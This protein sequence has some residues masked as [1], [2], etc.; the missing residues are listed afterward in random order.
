MVDRFIAVS[1]Y[2]ARF[3]CG[4]LRIPSEK[5][6]VVPLGIDMSGYGRRAQSDEGVFRIG[7][8][9]RIAPEKGLRELVQAY[10]KLRQRTEGRHIRLEA[11]GYTSP[12]NAGYMVESRDLL[13]AAGLED[14]F[15]YLGVVDREGKL[16][17]LEQL[18][19]LSVPATYDEPKGLFLLEA[20]ANGVPVV[21][22]R[23]GA[24]TEIVE[25]TGGGLLVEPDDID[26]LAE[27]LYTLWKD[28][29]RTEVLGE[30]A[31]AG[32]RQHYT[33]GQSAQ[34]LLDVYEEVLARS[35]GNLEFA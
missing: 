26:S 25:R 18:D 20:M 22:P 4:Y 31:L 28:P 2:A 16:R 6:S 19:V 5:M 3:M 35:A 17:F 14:E 32:V 15:D 9:A 8:F 12:D 33:V 13:K 10:I 30:R 24:F 21:Q 7:Y 1:E 29:G 23:R 11:A 27:G 34:R